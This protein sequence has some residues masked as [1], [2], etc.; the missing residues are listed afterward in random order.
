M[1]RGLKAW[2]SAGGGRQAGPAN[3]GGKRWSAWAWQ[4]SSAHTHALAVRAG[5]SAGTYLHDAGVQSHQ[6]KLTGE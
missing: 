3:K 2:F 6:F 1:E 4:A 5:R